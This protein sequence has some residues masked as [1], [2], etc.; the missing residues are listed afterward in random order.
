MTIC[1]FPNILASFIFKSSS[2]A[3]SSYFQIQTQARLY[4]LL[5]ISFKTNSIKTNKAFTCRCRPGRRRLQEP[6]SWCFGSGPWYRRSYSGH[7]F[8][9]LSAISSH[10]QFP[11]ERTRTHLRGS[12]ETNSA[13]V[14][15]QT[16]VNSV[17]VFILMHLSFWSG[18][19]C[20]VARDHG[21]CCLHDYTTITADENLTWLKQKRYGL[22]TV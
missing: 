5:Q 3:A 14:R 20:E 6:P 7:S 17:N 10:L 13:P 16:Q 8:E 22:G 11:R 19:I 9:R 18:F 1:T 2:K 15:K 4:R 12:E 21:S